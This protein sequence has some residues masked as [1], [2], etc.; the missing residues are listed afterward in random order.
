[1]LS[2]ETKKYKQNIQNRVA[3]FP[4]ISEYF[5]VKTFALQELISSTTAA[6]PLKVSGIRARFVVTAVKQ[7][8]VRLLSLRKPRPP[9]REKQG[10]PLSEEPAPLRHGAAARLD[11]RKKDTKI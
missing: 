10:R 8:K 2:G 1:M 5:V 4:Q 11:F 9:L 7:I 6:D 3:V